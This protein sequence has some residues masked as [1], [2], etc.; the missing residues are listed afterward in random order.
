[1]TILYNKHLILYSLFQN[2]IFLIQNCY[3]VR[4]LFCFL[5][6]I[7]VISEFCENVEE[8]IFKRNKKKILNKRELI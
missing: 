7:S 1:M 4:F 8:I 6:I 5:L 3:I 2:N